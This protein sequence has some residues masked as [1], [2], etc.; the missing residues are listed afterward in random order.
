M[1]TMTISFEVEVWCGGCGE[2]LCRQS[3][4]V[5]GRDGDRGVSVQPCQKCLKEAEAKGYDA[6]F[7]A[8]EDVVDKA[9]N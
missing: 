9:L 5:G 7:A 2:G 6:G 8:A 4:T 3:D 1:P